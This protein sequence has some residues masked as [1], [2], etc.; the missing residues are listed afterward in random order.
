M[1]TAMELLPPTSGFFFGSHTID[2]WYWQD[3]KDTIE[4]LDTALEQSVDDATF[5]YLASW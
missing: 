5:E 3:I 1:E 4:K 2:E